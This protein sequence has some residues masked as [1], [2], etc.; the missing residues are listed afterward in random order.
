MTKETIMKIYIIS[1]YSELHHREYII[2]CH[3]TRQSAEEAL[4]PFPKDEYHINEILE[5]TL[6]P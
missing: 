4:K 3:S 5:F 6:N 1:E 2:S